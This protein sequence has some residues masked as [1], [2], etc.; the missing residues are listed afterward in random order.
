MEMKTFKNHLLNHQ[1]LENRDKSPASPF[2]F[3]FS[4]MATKTLRWEEIVHAHIDGGQPG[5][6]HKRIIFRKEVMEDGDGN[7]NPFVGRC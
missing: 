7:W 5:T 4:S 3:I 6:I 2:L 1:L